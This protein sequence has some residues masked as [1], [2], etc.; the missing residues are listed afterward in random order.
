MNKI[1][2]FLKNLSNKLIYLIKLKLLKDKQLIDL[3]KF[4]SSKDSLFDF[5]LKQ[6]S[7]VFDVGGFEGSFGEVLGF[8]FGSNQGLT[9]LL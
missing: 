5:D 9:G 2:I 4:Y 8:M 1:K 3:E 6:E 7:I